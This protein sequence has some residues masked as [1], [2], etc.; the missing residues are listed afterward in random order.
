MAVCRQY[1]QRL[2]GSAPASLR[3]KTILHRSGFRW[4][5]SQMPFLPV[6]RSW[7][8]LQNACFL[9]MLCLQVHG[10]IQEHEYQDFRVQ[11][12][13]F[14]CQGGI[15]WNS[16]CRSS[17]VK[18][19]EDPERLLRRLLFLKARPGGCWLPA[20]TLQGFLQR[21]RLLV[22][23]HPVFQSGRIPESSDGTVF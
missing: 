9:Q 19:P 17:R 13:I 5:Q 21:F 4:K 8:V 3:L 18:S 15:P 11:P 12:W 20:G 7:Q 14:S 6:F 2:R 22:F 16:G 10:T 1:L 23:S